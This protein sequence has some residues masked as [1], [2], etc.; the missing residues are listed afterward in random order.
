MQTLITVL[1][2]LLHKNVERKLLVWVWFMYRNSCDSPARLHTCSVIR[3]YS[4]GIRFVIIFHIYKI[5]RWRAPSPRGVHPWARAWPRF[6]PLS[7]D[8]KASFR[9]YVTVICRFRVLLYPLSNLQGMFQEQPVLDTHPFWGAGGLGV[10][11]LNAVM[12]FWQMVFSLCKKA[13]I[14]T[15]AETPLWEFGHVS[16]GSFC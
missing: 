16:L 7:P 8:P 15:G 14:D 13:Q 1:W 4:K 3:K 12:Y 9:A 11:D 2:K 5:S 6:S 10:V